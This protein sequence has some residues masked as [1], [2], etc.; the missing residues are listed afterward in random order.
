MGLRSMV[1]LTNFYDFKFLLP[2][3]NQMFYL[4]FISFVLVFSERITGPSLYVFSEVICELYAISQY[5]S[6]LL[7][8]IL[9]DKNI[10]S[11]YCAFQKRRAWSNL[12]L[13]KYFACLD[14][15]FLLRLPMTPAILGKQYRSVRNHRIGKF[16]QVTLL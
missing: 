7:I 8:F 6:I 16:L 12:I 1:L 4:V 3:L 14:I 5:L 10:S 15:R 9:A 13:T 11:S 2:L